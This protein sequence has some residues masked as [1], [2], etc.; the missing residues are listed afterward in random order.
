[1]RIERFEDI[2]AWQEAR[3]LTS[4]IY[5]ITKSS[6]F[7]KDF[8]LQDQIRRASVSVMANIAEGFGR[9]SNK[10]FIQFL[11]YAS[12]SNLE[13]QSHLYVALDQNYITGEKF[14]EIYKKAKD[15]GNL[16]NG[17]IAYLK[18]ASKQHKSRVSRLK[19][20]KGDTK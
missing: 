15:V 8:G 13:L 12:S 14:N 1:M 2:K 18:K 6:Q 7:M 20:L 3:K 10:E 4:K 9:S 16:V 5:G 17:F 11:N 19:S